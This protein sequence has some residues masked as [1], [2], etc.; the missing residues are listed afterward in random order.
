MKEY[1]LTRFNDYHDN[2][3]VL[4]STEEKYVAHAK[5]TLSE[6]Y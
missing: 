2:V 1:N 5:E 3:E 6:M 4:C